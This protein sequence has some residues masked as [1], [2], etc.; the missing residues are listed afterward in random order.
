MHGLT[1]SQKNSFN[2]RMIWWESLA[3]DTVLA[4][5]LKR[6][7]PASKTSWEHSKLLMN[8]NGKKA[9][10]GISAFF[11]CV[12]IYKP[13]PAFQMLALRPTKTFAI[14]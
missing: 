4:A 14:P 11:H 7:L 12:Y 9:C 5:E 1:G 2:I 10:V 8:L 3:L 13:H 6:N